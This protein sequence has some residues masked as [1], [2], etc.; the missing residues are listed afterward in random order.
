ME[1]GASSSRTRFEITTQRP[2]AI[3]M[4]VMAI[5]VF[6]WVSY[7]RLSLDLMPDISYPTLTVRTEYPGTAPAEVETFISRPLEQELGVVTNLV[8]I[9]SVSQAGQ[10]DV[11]LEFEWDTD[12]NA[13][14]QDIREKVDRV[15]L[16]EDAKRP[17]LLRYDPSLDPIIRIALHGVLSMYEL[18]QLADQEIK[19]KLEALAGVAAVKVKGGLEEQ[20]HVALNERQMALLGIDID[21]VNSLLAQDNV[22]LP[23]GILRE[24][25]VQYLI[26]TLNEYRSVDEI[27]DLIVTRQDDAGNPLAGHRGGF[28]VSRG[29]GGHYAGQRPRERRNRYLQGGGCQYCRRGRASSV[30]SLRQ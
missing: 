28:A 29:S 2:V 12:M 5:C 11:I 14:S 19:R 20:I 30:P 6:G 15:R 26:R 21:Q 18:R 16:P 9:S 17:L 25:Q 22:N 23:G 7:Q 13:A 27:A 8:G 24:G 3:L 1:Q 10:S 4:I